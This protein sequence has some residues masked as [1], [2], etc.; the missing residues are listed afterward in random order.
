MP[1]ESLPRAAVEQS[2]WLEAEF[3]T[4]GGHVGFLDGALG[5]SSWAERRALAFLRRHLLR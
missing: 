2:S 1:A 4:Q 5:A 3:V